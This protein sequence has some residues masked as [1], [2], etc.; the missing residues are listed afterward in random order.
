VTQEDRKRT[1]GM[2]EMQQFAQQ[3]EQQRTAPLPQAEPPPIPPFPPRVI[4]TLWVS[5]AVGAVLGYL[6]GVILHEGWLVIQGWD[7]LYSM[8]PGA[9]KT[10][11]LAA[12]AAL[13]I[14]A[15]GVITAFIDLGPGDRTAPK[16]E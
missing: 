11:W 3:V 15:A 7:P 6:F 14:L 9:F 5:I 10:F 8:A 13:G 4:R 1:D 2:S 12:G 16:G